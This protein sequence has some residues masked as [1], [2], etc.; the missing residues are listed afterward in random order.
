MTAGSEPASAEK[1]L[2]QLTRE[3]ELLISAGLVL[4]LLQLPTLLDTWWARTS[5]HMGGAAF[6]TVF[7]MYYVG[8]LV[9]YG[10]I[11]AIASHFLMRG[12][13]VAI[14]GLR[15]V[16]PDGVRRDKLD[17]GEI[18]SKFYESRLMTLDQIEERVDRVSA[19]VFAFVFLFLMMFA[20]L[21]TWAAVGAG[22]AWLVTKIAGTDRYVMAIMIGTFVLYLVPQSFAASIDKM[23]K[24]RKVSPGVERAALKSMGFM[25][26]ATFNFLYA[27]V[28]FTFASHTSRRK[29]SALLVSFMY[30]MIGVFILSMF[31]A[32]GLLRYD[33]Y[34]YYPDQAREHQLRP[35]HYDNLRDPERPADIPSIQSDTI[36]GDYLRLFVPYD[37]RED[38]KR[39][40]AICP[41]VAPL[42]SE[43]FFFASRDKLPAARIAELSGC[44]DKLYQIALDGNPLQNPGFVF[45]RH[46]A[47]SVAGRLALIPASTL[48]PGRHLLTVRHAPLPGVKK[49]DEADEYFIPFWR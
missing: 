47:A 4:A 1:S 19:S 23:T 45:Y 33:S 13:W 12:F 17:Q 41:E 10:L 2:F 21:T 35:A 8:K 27:P 29:M 46:P 22:I 9:S 26:Y 24:K 25:H 36:E 44:F 32:R 16:F 31:S 3:L 42:R 38:N 6:G 30:A 20:V 5:V 15:S 28:F 43:G 37:A 39:I 49:D 7:T 48:T 40:R 34:V 14:M 18:A 11:V